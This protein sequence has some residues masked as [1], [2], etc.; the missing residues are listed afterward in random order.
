MINLR[1]K[2]LLVVAHPDDEAFCMGGIIALAVKSRAR[3]Q[4]VCATRGEKGKHNLKKSVS[5][6]RL[7]KIRSRELEKALLV[8][9]AEAPIF[10]NYL[11]G[12][13]N[14]ANE[15]EIIFK[16]TKIIRQI[17]PYNVIT[18]G[19]DGITGHRD[20]I[21][22]SR[23]ASK[24][25]QITFKE[26]N[27]PKELYWRVN[28]SAE[29]KI[30]QQMFISRQKTEKHYQ[31]ELIKLLY[32]DQDLFKMDISSFIDLKLKAAQ[33]HKSQNPELFLKDFQKISEK[34]WHYETFCKVTNKMLNLIG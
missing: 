30:F 27:G 14:Q 29:N 28:S 5:E 33:E 20:H 10:L 24:A 31:K 17:K 25:F 4:V 9:G 6:K 34:F 18:F 12:L 7:G 8:L 32:T 11:D 21:A 3:I 16:I 26:K 23:F 1:K 15:K 22:I 2:M 19:P 13:L